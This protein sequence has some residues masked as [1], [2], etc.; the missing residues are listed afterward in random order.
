MLYRF[1]LVAISL[2]KTMIVSVKTYKN[3]AETELYIYWQLF[4]NLQISKPY[5]YYT[6]NSIYNA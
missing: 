4:T 6:E 5:T 1:D 3:P 2:F